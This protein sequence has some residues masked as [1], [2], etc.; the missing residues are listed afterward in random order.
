MQEFYYHDKPSLQAILERLAIAANGAVCQSYNYCKY[1]AEPQTIL[2][3]SNTPCAD[4]YLRS[5]ATTVYCTDSWYTGAA[6][7]CR[8]FVTYKAKPGVLGTV[9]Y[10]DN[11]VDCR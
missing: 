2:R 5:C 8:K 11:L 6:K 9:D 3:I 10:V 4:A 1:C 7:D